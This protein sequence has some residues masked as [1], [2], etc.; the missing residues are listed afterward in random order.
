MELRP[1]LLLPRLDE[2]EVA[3]LAAIADCLDGAWTDH[4]EAD[5]AAFNRA[6]G[7]AAGREVCGPAWPAT[8]ASHRVSASWIA[9]LSSGRISRRDGRVV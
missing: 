5:L 3:R 2:A 4:P 9:V 8:S 6:A 7:G 1:E